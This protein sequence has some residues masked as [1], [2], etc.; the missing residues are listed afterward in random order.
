MHDIINTSNFLLSEVFKEGSSIEQYILIR[1]PKAVSYVGPHSAKSPRRLFD[2]VR[3]DVPPRCRALP[4]S[5]TPGGHE[6]GSQ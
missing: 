1:G 2:K 6:V 4:N 5:D 3:R